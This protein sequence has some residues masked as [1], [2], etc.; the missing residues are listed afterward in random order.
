M[1][2]DQPGTVAIGTAAGEE[3]VLG[4]RMV[5]I[6]LATA[7]YQVIDLGALDTNE[8]YVEAVRTLA[9]DVLALSV[10]TPAFV[11]Q[12]EQILQALTAAGLRDQV[13]VLVGGSAMNESVARQIGAD[14]FGLSARDAVKLT[15]KLLAKA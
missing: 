6:A 14:M 4:K 13:K 5:V 11:A 10:S 1:R 3:H 7:G 9:P 15:G 12:V 2:E 8:K